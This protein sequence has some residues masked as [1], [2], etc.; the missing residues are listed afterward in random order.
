MCH[1]DFIYLSMLYLGIILE[2]ARVGEPNILQVCRQAFAFWWLGTGMALN[3]HFNNNC[4]ISLSEC[5]NW[6]YVLLLVICHAWR[7]INFLSAVQM[8]MNHSW[9]LHSF[10]MGF[11]HPFLGII[12]GLACVGDPTHCRCVGRRLSFRGLVRVRS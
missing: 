2:L 7:F 8:H 12:L 9:F 6:W 5:L 4:V 10:D 11:E 1:D 3:L